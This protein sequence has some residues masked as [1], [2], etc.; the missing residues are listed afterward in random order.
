MALFQQ[1][2]LIAANHMQQP[3]QSPQIQVQN[4]TQNQLAHNRPLD[5]KRILEIKIQSLVIEKPMQKIEQEEPIVLRTG[6]VTRNRIPYH[7]KVP[8]PRN[9]QTKLMDFYH[10]GVPEFEIVSLANFS[11]IALLPLHQ[12]PTTLSLSHSFCSGR[13]R[14]EAA[15]HDRHAR[16]HASLSLAACR[17]AR[18]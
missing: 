5:L 17:S 16:N 1:S 13:S 3:Q 8:E 2:E 7:T 12:N 14:S 4:G 15:E 10:K 11:T 6:R 18:I 9:D